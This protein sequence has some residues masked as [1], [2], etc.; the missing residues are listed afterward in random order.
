MKLA[1]FEAIVR[2]LND[3][4]VRYLVVGGVAVNA[5]GFGRVTYDVDVVIGLELGNVRAAFAALRGADYQPAVP[6]VA[7]E[8]ADRA[9][10]ESWRVER[11]M[12][13]LQFWSNRHR[14]TP[15][16]VFISEPFP[17]EEE[18]REARREE[19]TP[20]LTVPYVRLD[21]LLAM[22]R[23][24]GRGKDLIDI[25]ELNLLYGRPSSFDEP[26]A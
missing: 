11:G 21:T 9:K 17:F 7:E 14:E 26:P 1:S 22:K 20:G 2:A 3:G 18:W 6:I 12:L 4:G 8:F 16:D 24:A 13:L 25:D 15:V 10:R 23:A 19:L 5:H